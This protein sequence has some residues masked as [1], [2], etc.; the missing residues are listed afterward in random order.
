MTYEARYCAFVDILGFTGLVADLNAGRLTVP[1]MRDLLKEVHHPDVDRIKPFA[2]SDFRAQSISDAVCIS[3]ANN[4]DG[5]AHILHS[6]VALCFGLLKKG[7]FARGGLTKGRLYHDDEMVFGDALV[8]AH[9]LESTISRYPCILVPRSI[10]I[11]EAS[12]I[13][14]GLVCQANDGPFY[15]HTL[16]YLDLFATQPNSAVRRSFAASYNDIGKI[17]QK[18]F[19]E[20]VDTPQHFEKVQW[21]ARYWNETIRVRKLD[22]AKVNGPGVDPPPMV[23]G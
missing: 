10:A 18:R 7:Y 6:L 21:F 3:T 9:R 1:E 17:L 23:W 8:H 20:A 15:V 16:M 4:P 14:E 11:G 22:V 2:D 12:D 19:D 5:L 13:G